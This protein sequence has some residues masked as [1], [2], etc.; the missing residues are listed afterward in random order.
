M[1]A[2]CDICGKGTMFGHNV[3]HSNRRTK[4]VFKA[5]LRKVRVIENGKKKTIKVCMKCYKRLLKE[6][7]VVF[8]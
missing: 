3:S 5:N 8:A 6:G 1:A 2:R 4:R 7:K